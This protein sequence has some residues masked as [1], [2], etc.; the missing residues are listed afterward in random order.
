M[1]GRWK[2][3][4][5]SSPVT[6]RMAGI[7]ADMLLRFQRWS[8]QRVQRAFERLPRAGQIAVLVMGFSLAAFLFGK[9]LVTPGAG[10]NRVSVAFA[11][12]RPISVVPRDGAEMEKEVLARIRRARHYLDSLAKSPDGRMRLDSILARHPRLLDS[13]ALAEESLR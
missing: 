4:P 9:L 13:L 2:K 8:M 6:D 7:C 12:S 11:E 10:D 1:M 5:D 3:K